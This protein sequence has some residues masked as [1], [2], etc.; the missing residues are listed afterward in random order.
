MAKDNL[1]EKERALR[2]SEARY[3]SL[4]NSAA[5][6]VWTTD[7]SGNAVSDLFAWRTFTGQTP[8]DEASGWLEAFHPE[9]R[10]LIQDSW[11]DASAR[12]SSFRIETRLRRWDGEFR[13]V[14][15]RGVPVV[16]EQSAI[17]EWV[18]AFIDVTER[19]ETD[20]RRSLTNELLSLFARNESSRDY[21]DAVVGVLAASLGC[22]AV[23]IRVTNGDI[24]LGQAWTG[25]EEKFIELESRLSLCHDSCCCIRAVT[26]KHDPEDQPLLTAAGSYLAPDLRA[27]HESLTPKRKGGCAAIASSSGSGQLPLC[28]S[29]VATRCSAPFT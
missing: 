9:D 12:V 1:I 13:R 11:R 25:Y 18:W 14:A 6:A 5:Q 16:D 23:G 28:L 24:L 29:G 20:R 19:Y 10:L 15:L 4:V 2:D 8:R 17:R 27:H 21:L 3:R 7:T 26:G 22:R